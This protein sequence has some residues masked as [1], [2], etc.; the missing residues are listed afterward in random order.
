MVAWLRWPEVRGLILVMVLAALG[1]AAWAIRHYS[2]PVIEQ[3]GQIVD[4]ALAL[5]QAHALAAEGKD[6]PPLQ[7]AARARAELGGREVDLDIAL[8][9]LVGAL[10]DGHSFYMSRSQAQVFQAAPGQAQ[11]PSTALGELQAPV[12]GLA[13]LKLDGFPSIQPEQMRL[14]ASHLR[15]QLLLALAQSPC[16]L[17]L[18]L[19]A[20]TGGNMYP[21]LAGLAALLPEGPVL[22]FEDARGRREPLLLQN[23]QLRYAQTNP[24]G[25]GAEAA[26]PSADPAWRSHAVAVLGG[27]FTGSSGEMV[28]IAFKAR[29]NTRFFGQPSAGV[30]TGN[31]VH[32]LR[33]G[34]LLALAGVRTL[35]RQGRL[36]S[37]PI[38]PDEI[39]GGAQADADTLARAAR[40]LHSTCGAAP[41][42]GRA[43]PL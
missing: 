27:P 23:G 39:S 40:W 6:W 41:P 12:Q 30:N 37:G 17:V 16:G 18:D 26:L 14:A 19:R 10:G 7:A 31:S 33:H 34:G 20:N 28:L 15:D 24:M 22:S 42:A 25:E 21:M 11:A 32:A 36:Y 29:A 2:S 3:P 13:V 38:A 35:D 9:Q 5:I 43:A 4:E 8:S 1:A